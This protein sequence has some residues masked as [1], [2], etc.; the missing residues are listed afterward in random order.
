MGWDVR[1]MGVGRERDSKYRKAV[2]KI[3]NNSEVEQLVTASR[4][5]VQRKLFIEI[6]SIQSWPI[7][8]SQLKITHCRIENIESFY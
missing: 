4:I 3:E 6:D 5:D 8:I 7:C 1:T 2:P